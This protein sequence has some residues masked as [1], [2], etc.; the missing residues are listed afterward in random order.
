MPHAR[1]DKQL[2]AKTIQ[3]R[4]YALVKGSGKFDSCREIIALIGRDEESIITRKG[5]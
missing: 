4:Y 3:K 5:S 2:Q 1:L